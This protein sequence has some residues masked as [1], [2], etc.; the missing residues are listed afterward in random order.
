MFIYEILFLKLL[1]ILQ[2][3]PAEDNKGG[4]LIQNKIIQ[5]FLNLLKQNDGLIMANISIYFDSNSIELIIA[6]L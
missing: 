2:F 3:Y 1:S 4:S 6:P 5:L